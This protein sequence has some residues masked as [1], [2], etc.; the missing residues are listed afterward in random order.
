MLNTDYVFLKELRIMGVLQRFAI[1]YFF[2]ASLHLLSVYRGNKFLTRPE[3]PSY[4]QILGVF[5]PE[6]LTHTGFLGIYLY[7][8]FAFNYDEGCPRG[9]QG[10]GG[11][12]RRGQFFNCT[13][14]AANYIDRLIL[15]EKHLYQ[16]STS[17]TIFKHTL[18]HDP[19][20]ILGL[21]TS[22][23]LTGVWID[24]WQNHDQ[25][26]FSLHSTH[27]M[28]HFV[29]CRWILG[30]WFG[31]HPNKRFPYRTNSCREK[32]VVSVIRFGNRIYCP[33]DLPHLLSLDRHD[34]GLEKRI[35]FSFRGIQCYS[36]VF[37]SSNYG[38]LFPL[39]LSSGQRQSCVAS[40]SMLSHYY[41]L[42]TH[43]N[44]PS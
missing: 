33:H 38:P 15:G 28:V 1:S 23:L 19:E 29:L 25:A 44:I 17:K 31:F 13:G 24:L 5:L 7:Y 22:I 6:I 11:L 42:V 37:G 14:G 26:S 36:L 3:E 43:C 40:F 30:L 16:W 4:S 18:N 10:P 8:T 9:Y 27:S 12:E 20:G 35:S 32:S 34:S 41:P 39:F 21:T 2:V